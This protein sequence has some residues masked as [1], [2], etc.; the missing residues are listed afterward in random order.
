MQQDPSATVYIVDDDLDM[1]ESLAWL[2]RSIGLEAQTYG[3]AEQFLNELPADPKGC[4]VLDVRMPQISGI[5]LYERLAAR[6]DPM[7]V[8]FMTAFA[9]VP[10]AIRAFKSG[11]TE[12]I[13]KPFNKQELLE[14]VQ[15]AIAKDEAARADRVQRDKTKS[16][17]DSLTR[18][19]AEVL[20]MLM[21]GLPN[22]SIAAKLGI[23]ER[24]VEMRRATLTKKLGVSSLAEMIRLIADYD[25]L[26]KG[27]GPKT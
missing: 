1:R 7:P 17:M 25:R 9:D 18:K 26:S 27:T 2:V 16:L 21:S 11:A 15:R 5:E 6:G 20:E 12:F 10:M 22:K 3:S 8:I 13:E 23:T 19:E 4:L 24:A 14:R